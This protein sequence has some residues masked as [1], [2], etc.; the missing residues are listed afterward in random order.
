MTFYRFLIIAAL[1]SAC[2]LPVKYRPNIDTN[3]YDRY[4]I[5]GTEYESPL[6]LSRKE[7]TNSVLTLLLK[8]DSSYLIHI[9]SDERPLETFAGTYDVS[10]RGLVRLAGIHPFKKNE[11]QIRESRNFEYRFNDHFSDNYKRKQYAYCELGGI[12][13]EECIK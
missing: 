6:D 5:F 10:N 8:Q 7:S 13:Y 3:R 12:D 11:I 2:T 9:R 4:C 1:F